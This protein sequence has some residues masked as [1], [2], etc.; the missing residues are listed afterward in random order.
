MTT[1]DTL[2]LGARPLPNKVIF[3]DMDGV[4]N[5]AYFFKSKRD[6]D[7]VVEYSQSDDFFRGMIDPVAVGVL[8]EIAV[9]SGAALVLS[10]SWRMVITLEDLEPM[11]RDAG[12]KGRGFVGKTDSRGARRHE[13]IRRYVAQ[14]PE[15]DRFLVLDDTRD[16]DVPGHSIITSHALGLVPAHVLPALSILGDAK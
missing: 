3:L 7:A 5:S 8:S 4:L 1:P 16:A 12:Y 15:I 14:H 2:T 9:R 6:A 13:E 11:L 10:S